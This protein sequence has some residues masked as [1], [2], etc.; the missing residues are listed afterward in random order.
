MRYAQRAVV[1]AMITVR[2]VEVPADQIVRMVAVGDRL[3]AAARTV[4]VRDFVAAALVAGGTLLG[5][6]PAHGKKN[7]EF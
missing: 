2:V 7:T 6:L 4:N 1:V 3:V 5:M